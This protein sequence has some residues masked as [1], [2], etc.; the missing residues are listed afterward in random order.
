MQYR[1]Q[2]STDD[3]AQGRAGGSGIR[4][5]SFYQTAR[6]LDGKRDF[7]IF[8]RN[9]MLESLR[10]LE[11]AIGLAFGD[12]ATLGKAFG[13]LGQRSRAL[14]QGASRIEPLGPLNICGARH[15]TYKYVFLC[16]KSRTFS[17]SL[18]L[19]LMGNGSVKLKV[20][21]CVQAVISP[22]LANIYLHYAFDRWMAKHYPQVPF[23]RF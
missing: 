7:G 21:F 6:K 13:G 8:D 18:P 10:L 1:Q 17:C 15:E 11:I 22:L 20:I 16:N 5:E 4:P 14:H 3:L 23:E 12:G 9:R 19:L 2:G